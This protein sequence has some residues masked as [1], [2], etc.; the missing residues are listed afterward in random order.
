MSAQH[1]N[2]HLSDLNNIITE[3]TRGQNR[4][5]HLNSYFMK[6]T[7][8]KKMLVREKVFTNQEWGGE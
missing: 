6:S 1:Q 7:Y 5:D 4:M 8:V 3:Q 2:I